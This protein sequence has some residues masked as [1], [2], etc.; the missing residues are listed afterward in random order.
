MSQEQQEPDASTT[1]ENAWFTTEEAAHYVKVH[2]RTIQK[3]VRRK[4]LPAS[5]I[6]R[7]VRI[8]KDDIDAF[9]KNHPA[10]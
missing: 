6:G 3:L 10:T 5:R 9:M 7:A 8:H 1:Y 4:Q 2:P